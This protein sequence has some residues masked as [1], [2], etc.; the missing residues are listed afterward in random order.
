MQLIQKNFVNKTKNK[1]IKISK[2]K[3][4]KIYK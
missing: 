4:N 2:N 3:K 1:H